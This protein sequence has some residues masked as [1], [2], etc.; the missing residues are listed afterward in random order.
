MARLLMR[1]GTSY[2]DAGATAADAVDGTVSVTTTG[3]VTVGTVGDY[4]L[5]YSATDAAGNTST[6]Y[7]GC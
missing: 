5:T 6:C 7:E 1:A 4:T 3:S 2:T